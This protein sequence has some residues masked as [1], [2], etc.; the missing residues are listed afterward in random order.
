MTPKWTSALAAVI[1]LA[2][3]GTPLQA[4][5]PKA[6]MQQPLTRFIHTVPKP[7]IWPATI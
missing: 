7:I 1:A 3:S 2:L 4:Q 6:W 5:Q